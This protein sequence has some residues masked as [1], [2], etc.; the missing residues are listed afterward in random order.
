MLQLHLHSRLNI[1][2]QWIAQR[3]QTARRN[4]KHL[5]FVIWCGL[6]WRFDGILIVQCRRE[7]VSDHILALEVCLGLVLKRCDSIIYKEELFIS[8]SLQYLSLWF[9][10]SIIWALFQYNDHLS[11]YIKPHFKGKMV[12]LSPYLYNVISYFGKM[13][14]QYWSGPVFQAIW[15]V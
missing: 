2:L 6:Y 5:S 14:F 10:T 9:I 4:E 12:I 3:W 7:C 8:H 15:V 1:W 11:K 13:A